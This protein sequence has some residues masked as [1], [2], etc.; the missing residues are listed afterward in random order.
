MPSQ[1]N[2]AMDETTAGSETTAPQDPAA[3]SQ[4]GGSTSSSGGATTTPADGSG[5]SSGPTGSSG[6]TGSG[7]SGA[8]QPDLKTV[9][10][11]MVALVDQLIALAPDLRSYNKAEQKAQTS[12]RGFP[13]TFVEEAGVLA[14]LY[15]MI[16]Q[17]VDESRLQADYVKLIAPVCLRLRDFLH[18]L[19][20]TVNAKRSDNGKVALEVYSLA[21]SLARTPQATQ[22]LQNSVDNMKKALGRSGRT[23]KPKAPAAGSP[24][25]PGATPAPTPSVPTAPATV[26]HPA[27]AAPVAAPAP[28]APVPEAAPPRLM[29]PL[30]TS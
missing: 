8:P 12:T 9:A 21:Q 1:W 20:F 16:G 13:A 27:A 10:D 11:Q 29:P 7:G 15:P 25:H 23:K 24:A 2:A 18:N 3:G 22:D 6:G 5:S 19:T 4:A 17:A 14:R 30:R 26:Q 28:A